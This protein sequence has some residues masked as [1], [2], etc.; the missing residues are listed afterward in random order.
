MAY[1]TD[2]VSMPWARNKFTNPNIDE[3]FGA[4]M[5]RNARQ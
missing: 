3:L 4:F 5:A 2:L 1:K